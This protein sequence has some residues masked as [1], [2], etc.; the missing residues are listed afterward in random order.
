MVKNTIIKQLESYDIYVF[1]LN[2][3]SIIFLIISIFVTSYGLLLDNANYILSSSIISIIINPMIGISI[4]I[5]TNK[6]NK[7]NKLLYHSIIIISL[8]LL[9]SFSIGYFNANYNYIN[10]P[11]EQ[12]LILGNFKKSFFSIECLIAIIC[13]IGMYYSI[14]KSNII[15]IFG[16]VLIFSITPPIANAGLFYGMYLNNNSNMKDIN[17]YLEYGNNSFMLSIINIIG[18]IIGLSSALLFNCN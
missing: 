17:K 12:M 13:G 15:S 3:I 11:T 2:C 1:R 14:M 6:F 7:L 10:E 16:F 8:S 5:A 4:L 9:I 18:M